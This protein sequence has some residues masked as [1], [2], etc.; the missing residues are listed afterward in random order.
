MYISPRKRKQYTIIA[1]VVAVIL[2]PASIAAVLLYR[3]WRSSAKPTAKPEEVRISDLTDTSVTISWITPD[4]PTEGW[5]Q[6]G[7]QSGVGD[8]SPLVQ[9][10]RDVRSGTTDQRTTHYVTL[11]D[12]DPGTTYYYMIGSGGERY[13]DTTGS[14]FT[15]TTYSVGADTIPTPD[16]VYGTITNGTNQRAI[17]YV[18]LQNGTEK[19]FPVSSTTNDSGNFEID[20]AH[21]RTASLDSFFPYTNETEMIIFA[22][23]GDLGGGTLRA[24]IGQRDQLSLTMDQDYSTEDIFADSSSVDV[25]DVD[26]GSGSGSGTG[27]GT[28][29]GD[30]SGDFLPGTDGDGDGDDD[31]DSDTSGGD[32]PSGRQDVPLTALVLGTT[33]TDTGISD[34]TV[35]NVTENSFTIVWESGAKEVGSVIY[36]ESESELTEEAS[37][38][39]DGI[40]TTGDYYMHHVPVTDLTPE[41]TYYYK[42]VSGGEQYD[43]S[44]S[45]Y[46]ITTPAT[47]DS[48]PQYD[49]IVGE[50]LG[51]GSTDSVIIAYVK[52]DSGESSDVSAVTDSNGRWTLSIGGVRTSDYSQYFSYTTEDQLFVTAKTKG[53]EFSQAYDLSGL[54]EDLISIELDMTEPVGQGGAEEFERG[55]YGSISST[56]S[57]LPVTAVNTITVVGILISLALFAS[58]SLLLAS[59]YREERS[60]KWERSVIEGFDG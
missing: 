51:S 44:G 30:G 19:S 35:T 47:Q 6:Y 40:T 60:K 36:G 57:N 42:I 55:L 49:A 56:L 31:G 22:Q 13:K 12:L 25:G 1:I 9:D 41:T 24:S 45:A 54:S 43:D 32:E 8:G 3:D 37:D 27:T 4:Q 29:T 15:F 38:S 50:I 48:P 17:V 16:P 7:S 53:D 10:V 5:I 52:T 33:T 2:V 58:G 18:T 26:D 21:I 20:L 34:I 46:S 39:R 28:G 11:S 23:G 14:E 59:Y